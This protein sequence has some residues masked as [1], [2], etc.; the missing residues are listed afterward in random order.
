MNMKRT[1][2]L[3]AFIFAL[4]L[5]SC[6]APDSD[7]QGEPAITAP[8]EIIIPPFSDIGREKIAF[9]D[10][11]YTRPNTEELLSDLYALA[12]FA[13]E[14][15][16]DYDV[17]AQKIGD[18]DKKYAS[19]AT[20]SSLLLIKTS[21]NINDK[22]LQAEYELLTASAPD[23]TRGIEELFVTLASSEHAVRLEEE[24]FGE[25]FIDKYKHGSK[26]N[27]YTVS[28]LEKEAALEADYLALSPQ[29]VMIAFEGKTENY[30][31]TAERVKKK[32]AANPIKR[33]EALAEC[34]RL[35]NEALGNAT[36]DIYV[37]L[38]KLRHDIAL[39]FGHESYAEYAY[40]KLGHDYSAE[41]CDR[42][43][44]D[45]SEYAVAVYAS[46]SQRAFAGY[47]KT[48]T[49]ISAENARVVNSIFS[50]MEQLDGDFAA[51]YSYM[52][53]CG[54]YDI[55]DSEDKRRKISF[56]T[57][58]YD[59][60][61]PFVFATMNGNAED[62]TTLTH[63]F[64]HFYD[65]I[66]NDGDTSSIDIAEISSSAM[67]LLALTGFKDILTAEE[68][69]YLYYSEM[70][71]ALEVLIFQGF[72]AKFEALAYA[73]PYEEITK[74]RLDGLVK[75]AAGFMK[76][77]TE[78]LN[79][80][81]DVMIIH[82]ID[83]PFYVQSYCTSLL[84]SLDIFFAECEAA[85]SGTDAYKRL[86]SREGE[87]GFEEELSRAGLDS[88]FREGAL[89]LLLDKIYFSIIGSHFYDESADIIN[90]A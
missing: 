75:E 19:F 31:D 85:G 35:Y 56:T 44:S 65:N 34:E 7:M 29:S 74:E 8:E 12:A 90:A 6:G 28:L 52:L 78:Y 53:N 84:V 88:P 17:L 48:H 37:E 39:A 59:L 20:M 5:S 24:L 50:V 57:Y 36:S 82:L 61:A 1:A 47:F 32:Y 26:Y 62:F 80:L 55:S 69:K 70:R 11:E 16:V 15:G 87:C 41:A 40:E 89:P 63:E 79:S 51:A 23:V 9:S 60:D 81:A 86:L 4:M 2:F 64:G 21:A 76:L 18:V 77:N 49:P 72:Y 71:S 22:D 54:L 10:I 66:K 3:L 45:I 83:M 33:S 14:E 58:L 38:L 46:L 30:E 67:E 13:A 68:Y 43:L 25:G 27:D 73:L 42:L